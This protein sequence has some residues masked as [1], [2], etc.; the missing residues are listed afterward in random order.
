MIRD[1]TIS[2][3]LSNN[4][5]DADKMSVENIYI[6]SK[7]EQLIT[8]YYVTLEINKCEYQIIYLK[9][10]MQDFLIGIIDRFKFQIKWIFYIDMENI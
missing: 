2:N 1:R 5:L 8:G 10:I 9:M 4:R 7:D 3:H 6:G